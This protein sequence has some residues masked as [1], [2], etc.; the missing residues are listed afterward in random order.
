MIDFATLTGA[1]RVALGPDLPALMAR[2]DE[3]A[4][5]LLTAGLAHDDPCWRLP[6][7]E[8]YA[9]WLKSDIADTN[10]AHSNGFAGSS[11]AAAGDVN[12]DG[13]SD[14]LIGVPG[15]DNPEKSEGR[16]HLLLGSAAGISLTPAWTWE[17]NIAGVSCGSSVGGAGDV[18]GDGYGDIVVGCNAGARAYFFLG[19]P[20]G[21]ARTPRWTASR[22]RGWRR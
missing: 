3:T 2:R 9:E 15:F 8:A 4:E 16:V 12:G 20:S 13:H 7:P 14:V 22:S 10:N 11:V 21:P 19:S 17:S 1:A 5:A 18:N 6:L